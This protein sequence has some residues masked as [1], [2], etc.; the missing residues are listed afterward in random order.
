MRRPSPLP[1]W[2]SKEKTDR[3][4]QKRRWLDPVFED[5]DTPEA[6][7]TARAYHVSLRLAGQFVAFIVNLDSFLEDGY[8]YASQ[9][10][11]AARIKN[12]NGE[13]T[14]DRQV[15]RVIAF[16][17]ARRHLHV[18]RCSGTSNRMFP[19]YRAT[20]RVTPPPTEDTVSSDHG[21]D[22]RGVRTSCPPNPIVKPVSETYTPQSPPSG[23]SGNVVRLGERT[24]SSSHDRQ[25]M[26]CDHREKNKRPLIEGQEVIQHRLALRLGC[27]DV[28]AGYEILLELPD[29]QRD[30]LT[31]ME[32]IGKLRDTEI[33]RAR[34]SLRRESN[35]NRIC[36]S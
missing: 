30:E 35:L 21:H 33:C 11:L 4:R 8:V 13:P 10:A 24:A 20:Q 25:A 1:I 23:E 15:R 17:A 16:V 31:A 3:E 12:E 9:K 32:R 27:G 2:R 34:D 14:S 26:H 6:L 28:A 5:F 22:A 7:Q 19:L 18:E 36:E 29:N